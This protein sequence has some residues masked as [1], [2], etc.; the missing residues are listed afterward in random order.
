MDTTDPDI[1]FDEQ[2]VCN[3]CTA[4]LERMKTVVNTEPHHFEQVIERIRRA[5]C[6]KRYDCLLGVS[7][8]VDSTYLAYLT[9]KLGLRVLAVH[10]DNGWDSELAVQNIEHILNKLGVDLYTNVLDWESFRDL[11]LAFLMSSTPDSEIPTDHAIH[12]TLYQVA[13]R[14]G[15]RYILQG[16]NMRTEGIMPTSW[17][18]GAYDWSYIQG[19]YKHLGT[20][21]LQDFPHFSLVDRMMNFSVYR[22]QVV[23]LLNLIDYNKQE[24]MCVLKDELGWRDYGVKHG[25]SIYTR[26]Y[27]SYILPKK[28]GFDKRR[29]H[30][31]CLVVSGQISRDAALEMLKAPPYPAEIMQSD[32][33][34]VIKKLGISEDMFLQIMTAPP[35][36]FRDYPN[37]NNIIQKIGALIRMGRYFGILSPQSGL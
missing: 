6:G 28:F 19:I 10:L 12:A 26:F 22:L 8:G 25:E 23:C 9:K 30:L 35:K 27:Q 14:E 33:E 32:R 17:T 2:G 34:Y 1:Q 18:Y 37:Q 3:H 15:I 36:T 11:Q 29:A 24:A 5:G 4:M 20:L 16:M 21:K 7:G 31:S 13:R